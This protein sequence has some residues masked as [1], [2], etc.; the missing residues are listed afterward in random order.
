MMHE[1]M[2][3]MLQLALIIMFARVFG[4]FSSRVLKQ[5]SVLGELAAG[6]VIGPYALGGVRPAFFGGEPLFLVPPGSALPITP[7]LYG[8]A[9][10][11][12]IVLLFISGLDTD[13]KTFL[14]FAG[15]GSLVGLGGVVFSF[16]LGAGSAAVLVP[17]V[18][19]ITDPAAVFMGIST[20][21]SVGIAARILSERRKLSS[22][23]GVTILSAAVFDDVLGI[24]LLAAAA[25]LVRTGGT[26]SGGADWGLAGRIALKTFGFWLAGTVIGIILAPRLTRVLKGLGDLE[27]LA[28]ITFGLALL[29]AGLAESVGLAM[30]IGAYVTGLALSR[31]D[32]AEDI[33]RRLE[34]V[35]SLMVPVFFCVMGMLVDFSAIPGFLL[36]GAVYTVLGLTGKM[37]GCGIP[38]LFGGFSLRGALRIGAGMLARGEVTLIAAGL[39]LSMG[40]LDAGLFGAAVI[41]VFISSIIA[42]PT[43]I[44]AFR[45]GGGFRKTLDPG[46]REDIRTISLDLPSSSMSD[47]VLARLLTAFRRADFFPRR[48]DHRKPVYTVKKDAA[49]LTLLRSGSAITA[50]VPPD[51]ERFVRLLF[52]EEILSL[53]ELFR[54]AEQVAGSDKMERAML[55]GLFGSEPDKD[56]D[57]D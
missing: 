51:Q 38:A 28:A 35:Y 32:V 12:S 23:E 31:T 26:A 33:R 24:V 40:V 21:T 5:P 30:I 44:R 36:F 46:R 37:L 39:G 41:S 19:S 29:L 10:F 25:G 57:K 34:G 18:S 13:L 14:R 49:H 27:S 6:M 56:S 50:N 1:M 22:P 42:P 48:V 54:N 11:A 17:G 53:K 7:E 43:L 9:A 55:G 2:R 15:M 8:F 4:L 45:G 16:V 52:T 47:F 20:A 3:L